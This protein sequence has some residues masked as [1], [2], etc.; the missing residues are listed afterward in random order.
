MLG[1][2]GQEKRDFLVGFGPTSQAPP[3]QPVEDWSTL[4]KIFSL[5]QNLGDVGKGSAFPD[6]LSIE[7]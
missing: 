2:F 5:F 6:W 4:Q 7:A 3:E 1:R